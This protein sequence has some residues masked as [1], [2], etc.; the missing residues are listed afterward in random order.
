MLRISL[1]YIIPTSLIHSI[2]L[3]TMNTKTL[4][5]LA[6]PLL[7]LS[8]AKENPLIEESKERTLQEIVATKA[9]TP[10]HETPYFDWEDTSYVYIANHGNV[11]LP[12]IG[13]AE[14]N[15][16]P[17]I[18]HD[19]QKNRGWELVYNLCSDTELN[20]NAK[21]NY[22]VFYNKI[23]GT[24]R[25]YYYNT[26]T[27]STGSKDTFAHLTTS[28]PSRIWDFG[29]GT[30][31]LAPG[32]SASGSHLPNRTISP[33]TSSLT[34][35]WNCF[36]IELAYDPTSQ[37]HQDFTITLLDQIHYDMVFKGVLSGSA[38]GRI[39]SPVSS[40]SGKADIQQ[41]ASFAK[42]TLNEVSSII[43]N[44]NG[45]KGETKISGAA[46][47]SIVAAG[48]SIIQNLWG[49][50][51]NIS[52]PD[53]APSTATDNLTITMDARLSGAG[54]IE[55][56]TA[57][58]GVQPASNLLLPGTPASGSDMVMPH[59]NQKLGAW[60]IVNNPV[61]YLDAEYTP[62]VY[63]VLSGPPSYRPFG[64]NHE[65]YHSLGSVS[66]VINPE[67]LTYLDSYD[68]EVSYQY[69]YKYD[70]EYVG[71]NLN[72]TYLNFGYCNPKNQ[73][74]KKCIYEEN[75]DPDELQQYLN[76]YNALRELHELDAV[77]LSD[78][79]EEQR[80]KTI[81]FAV[82]P[83]FADRRLR[84]VNHTSFLIDQS[85][86]YYQALQMFNNG[87]IYP[88]GE[89]FTNYVMKVKMVFHIKQE[90]GGGDYVS[91]KTYV[92]TVQSRGV[93]H[94]VNTYYPYYMRPSEETEWD[95][96]AHRWDWANN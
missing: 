5:Y 37:S 88:A 31:A 72:S 78:L 94:H 24:L 74:L 12:W 44:A 60:N 91:V 13:G 76:S 56:A 15:I 83:E 73:Y 54:S 16:A 9:R 4:L 89:S 77:K 2:L 64:V 67:T 7:F 28:S 96:W 45:K 32:G 8:C 18:L 95:R 50:F 46:V 52:S 25:V 29:Q 42:N 57:T 19:Y 80:I 36:E 86:Q 81:Y 63:E 70:G 22:L 92:P 10:P 49:V 11:L 30:T 17:E 65:R 1:I 38:V 35:G 93:N 34:M 84:D 55:S 51:E 79:S 43:T 53:P 26:N 20:A 3:L 66:I 87:V 27:S 85:T 69:V 33:Y 82:D 6:F 90:Y 75:L 62:R 71:R 61:V 58:V 48:I 23:R 14:S 21:K 40:S 39:V 59:Y 68:Y 41:Y 47:V